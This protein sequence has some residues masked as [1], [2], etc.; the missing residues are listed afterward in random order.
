MADDNPYIFRDEAEPNEYFDAADNINDVLG[1]PSVRHPNDVSGG[2]IQG[3]MGVGDV[4]VYR[5]TVDTTKM[6][7]FA[8]GHTDPPSGTGS[9]GV[10]HYLFH[11][12]DL[13]T[14]AVNQGGVDK[15][16][17]DITGE[18]GDGRNGSND[19]RLT[20]WVSPVDAATGQMLTGDFYLWV[21]NEDNEPGSYVLYAYAIDR[22][23]WESKFEPNQTN[24]EALTGGGMFTLPTDAVARTFMLFNPDTLKNQEAGGGFIQANSVYPLLLGRGDEDVDHFIFDYKAG[25]TLVIETLPYLGWYRNKDGSEGP[26]GSRLS[27]PRIRL[28][29]GDYTTKLEE[30]DDGGR[31]V[32]DGPNNIHS[33]IVMSPDDMAA[34]GVTTDTPLWLW[35]SAWASTTRDPTFGTVNNDD[36]GAPDV[37]GV[38]ASV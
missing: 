16:S 12:S 29:D 10:Q 28:Y 30:D 8:S 1:M 25:H 23:P 20:G 26:G 3:D 32:M 7:Y 36:P 18:T 6:Y 34:G 15:M 38:P 17:G 5:F 4:D 9:Y 13:D 31:E 14:T 35:V 27:D 2:L 11:E 19:F 24:L 37:P 22:E 33:R 21:Y